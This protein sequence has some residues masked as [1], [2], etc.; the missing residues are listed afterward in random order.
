MKPLKKLLLILIIAIFSLGIYAQVSD[1]VYYERLYYT[2]KV[3]GHAKY[4]HSK[5]AAGEVDWDD[6]L[7]AA[8]PGI[9]NAPDNQAFNDSLLVMLLQAGETQAGTEP[10]PEVPDSLNNNTDLAWI[11]HPIFSNTVS[12][13]LDTI[14]QRFTPKDN[15]YVRHYPNTSRPD[16]LN[17]NK[18]YSG[19]QYPDEG[20]RILAVFR[21]WNVIHYF[22][23]RK[24]TMDQHWDTTLVQTIPAVVK[25][26][27]AT[28]YHLAMRAFTVKIDDSHAYFSSGT[29][30]SWR[31]S[32]YTPFFARFIE[33]QV[34]ITKIHPVT[35][36]I[37]LGDIIKKIDGF[38][39]DVLRDSLR[40]YSH[41]SNEISIEKNLI[42]LI[43]YGPAGQ[44]SV[45]VLNET[46]EHTFNLSRGNYYTYVTTDNTSEWR[47]IAH[48]KCRFGVVNLQTLKSHHFPEILDK[49]H[50]VDAVILDVRNYPD[51]V[52]GQIINYMLEVPTP[53][54]NVTYP[55]IYYPSAF[56]WDY[57]WAW[58]VNS[59]PISKKVM[60]LLDE[61][62][63]SWAE[64]LCM[65][66]EL[67]PGVIKIGSNTAG[68]L[69]AT[70]SIQLPG[71]IAT[72]ATF[73]VHYYPDYTPIHR[74][75][76]I[77]DY[78][79]R[80]TIQGIREGRDEILEFALNC[81]FVGINEIDRN[82]EILIYPN[83]TFGELRIKNYE[84]RIT[85]VEVFDILGRRQRFDFAQRPNAEG[86]V[87]MNISHLSQGVY[88]LKFTANGYI[89][90]QKIIKN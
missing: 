56:F 77:P 80:P 71:T 68:A 89:Y 41:G 37:N 76:I 47:E 72:N 17:D 30:I 16:F 25:S 8:L 83:P 38:D 31:G 50:T 78:Y 33:G 43:L 11:Y 9:K 1:S 73:V 34:V 23:S 40:K 12:A 44:F 59:D 48:N 7:L 65:A 21:Y 3:W 22:F 85:D 2:C 32:S 82:V 67:I 74:A 70:S 51:P 49:F 62:T 39:I 4:Y 57:Q 5:I 79:V 60:I 45:T 55:N 69:G 90:T 52:V 58:N 81:D 46:G 42:D 19:T 61:R 63:I 24:Y 64:Y 53:L 26:T 27:N 29:F 66:F 75:G 28:E 87:V 6:V 15:V 35:A 88:I 13:L 18:Y 36:E 84:L 54:A 14:M 86:E 20:K 10:L